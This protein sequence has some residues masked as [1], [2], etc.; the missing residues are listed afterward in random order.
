ME[1]AGGSPATVRK[2]LD[3]LSNEGT[4]TMPIDDPNHSG[5]GRAPKIWQRN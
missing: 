1:E 3:R 2:V 4:L 5:R